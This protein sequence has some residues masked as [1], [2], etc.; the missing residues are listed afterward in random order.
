MMTRSCVAAVLVALLASAPAI[1]R[2]DGTADEADL[3]FRMGRRDFA[4]GDYESALA[5]FMYS[6][7]LAPNRNVLF[8]IATAFEQLH[9]YVDAHRYYVDALEGESD[10][11]AQAA[12]RTAI[13]RLAPQVAVLE[14]VSSPPGATLY[15]DRKDLGSAGR[16]PRLLAVAPGRHRIVAELEGYEGRAVDGIEATTGNVTKVSVTL[17]R[18]LGKVH[19]D[20]EGAQA[21]SVRVDDDHGPVAC[22]APCD[23]DL[24]PGTHALYFAAEGATGEPRM[25]TVTAGGRVGTTARLRPLTGNIVVQADERGALIRVDGKPYG[26]TPDVIQAVPVGRHEVVVSLRDH[27]PARAQV[28]VRADQQADTGELKLLPL[29]EVEA[30]SR[31]KES[32]EDAPSSLTVITREELDAFGFPTIAAALYGVRGFTLSNDR[33]Y[34]SAGVRGLGQPD[35]YGN[36]LLVLADGMSLND[37]VANSSAIGSNARVD[38]HDVDRIEVVRGP[39]SLLYGTGA[40]SGVVNLVSRP[41][42][43]PS[44]AFVGF[45]VYDDTVVHGRAG[46][47]YNFKKD[48]SAGMWASVSAAHSE[49][50]D[51]TAPQPVLTVDNKTTATTAHQVDAFSSINTSGRAW[52]GPA[53]LQWFYNYRNQKVPVGA[54]GTPFDDPNTALADTRMMAELKV[55]PRL[56][57]QVELLVR[58]HANR[59]QSH[60]S[61]DAYAKAQPSVEDYTGTW[62][63]GEA[64]VIY[65]PIRA[66]S[67]TAGGEYQRHTQASMTGVSLAIPNMPQQSYMNEEHPYQFGAG[68]LLAETSPRPWVRAMLGARVDGYPGE[69]AT[70]GVG[71]IPVPRAALIFKPVTGGVLKIM[72]GRAFRAPS[73]YEE[74][75]HAT[76]YQNA[77][78]DG[79]H[80][81]DLK[82]ESI[83]SGEL[84]YSQRFKEDWVAL[85]AG[86]ADLAQG[87]I[88]NVK[89]PAS[90]IYMYQNSPPNIPALLVGGEAEI[91]R[92]FRRGWM[93]SASYGYEWA[94]FLS[95]PL[96]DAKLLNAPEHSASFRGVAP[97]IRELLSMALRLTLEAP[98]RISFASSQT[99]STALVADAVISGRIRDYGL[100]YAVGVYNIADVRY[101]VPVSQTFLTSTL[102]QNGRTFLVD[103]L[104]TYP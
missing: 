57:D 75:Y 40:L 35:D 81:H 85:L 47:H 2:A 66:L 41:R 14:V 69:A 46:F 86:Y 19:V 6:N 49:G 20:V 26:F 15:V 51:L 54:Y 3:H 39:G 33:A 31:R 8:N 44:G 58:A 50:Y 96:P 71:A 100:K 84:E 103:L 91:R 93:L 1:A 43:E 92:E 60:E 48:A 22:R 67:L 74:Y 78:D 37:N 32:V 10:P 90:G 52:W 76:N 18:V 36:R 25:V 94:R 28:D 38:L 68:Y 77:A 70:V 83:W 88:D 104:G 7:R 27:V 95:S 62:F 16:A 82:P 29:R 72:G 79:T 17:A 30:V 55:E 89:D 64:R 63:G 45:G 80:K 5:H 21:A 98:R 61:F 97:L 101:Q 99:T 11:G 13:A 42:D 56:G 53:T 59:Y 9:R 102:P 87:L 73:V 24:P 23:L 65:T 12:V 4:K 34:V